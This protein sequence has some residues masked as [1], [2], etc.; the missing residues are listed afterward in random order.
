MLWLD[1]SRDVRADSPTTLSAVELQTAQQEPV[2]SGES[3]DPGL[4]NASKPVR[5][6]AIMS[7]PPYLEGT[8]TTT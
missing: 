6:R 5:V 8:E 2:T 1:A 4:G 3:V 7:Y